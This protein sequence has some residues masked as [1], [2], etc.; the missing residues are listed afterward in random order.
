ME[1]QVEEE[2]DL[3]GRDK[4]LDI[5][6][7]RISY[8][9]FYGARKPAVLYLPAFDAPSHDLKA[10]RLKTYCEMEDHSFI[11]MEWYGRGSS[12]GEFEKGTISRWKAD[13]MTLIKALLPE[14]GEGA[15]IVGGGVGA[16]IATLIALDMPD[17]VGGIVGLAADPDF[18]ENLL[19]RYLPK[20]KIDEIFENGVATITWGQ[21]TYPVS[22][23][24]IE[25]AR[26]NLVLEGEAGGLPIR[27]PVRLV[28]GLDDEEVPYTVSLDLCRRLESENVNLHLVKTANHHLDGLY[29]LQVVVSSLKE[30]LAA[31]S[32]P[33][34]RT[35]PSQTF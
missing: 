34:M 29:I 19:M 4:F 31:Y 17:K 11:S 32:P 6:Q 26:K 24:L 20:A 10:S 2:P 14:Y 1:T 9:A 30:C 27:C 5:G 28:H 23:A 35:L 21:A 3:W 33:P 22:K 12:T 7:E 8:D 15:I 25:D 18:T 16:W 13:A